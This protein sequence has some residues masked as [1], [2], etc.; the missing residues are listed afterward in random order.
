[1]STKTY[2]ICMGILVIF[3]LTGSAY[4]LSQGESWLEVSDRLIRFLPAILIFT[5]LWVNRKAKIS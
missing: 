5:V 2:L 4:V 3:A 1:M